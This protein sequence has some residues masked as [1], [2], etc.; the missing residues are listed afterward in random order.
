P[1]DRR[2]RFEIGLALKRLEL[3]R[4]RNDA[5]AVADEA[6]RLLAC[7]EGS[8]SIEFGPGEGLRT[9]VLTSL[10]VAE[11]WAGR[12]EHAERDLARA[13][14]G[15]GAADRQ[16]DA[17]AGRACT[18]GAPELLPPL[19]GEGGAARQAGD[20]AGPET[21]LGGDGICRH[22]LRGICQGG[23]LAR[24]APGGGGVG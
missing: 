11:L 22:R 18:L 19:S 21:R 24:A 14:G 20:R 6:E 9:C 8:E 2:G 13:R 16:A 10:A 23:A 12:L 4:A 1:E 15:G 3:A 5:E 7:A 17:R